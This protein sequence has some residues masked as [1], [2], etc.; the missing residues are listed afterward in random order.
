[1]SDISIAWSPALGRG[2]WVQLGTQLQSGNDLANAVMISLFTD[3]TANSDDIIPDGTNDPRGWWGDDAA[4]PIGSRLWLLSR[5]KQTT[6]TLARAQDYIAEALQWP[7]ASM[8]GARVVAYEKG[9]AALTMN[10]ASAWNAALGLPAQ[11]V[12]QGLSLILS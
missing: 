2:D 7:R 1:M 10:S 12:T 6:E 9:G 3:R 8:L 4:V 11:T 5:A